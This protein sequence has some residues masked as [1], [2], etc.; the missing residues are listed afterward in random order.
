MISIISVT[1]AV[2]WVF[3]FGFVVFLLYYF[4]S[5]ER[6]PEEAMLHSFVFAIKVRIAA[7]CVEDEG[8]REDGYI[9]T[10]KI[11]AVELTM[12]KIGKKRSEKLR[13]KKETLKAPSIA[14]GSA[15]RML[16]VSVKAYIV[17]CSMQQ[18]EQRWL[19]CS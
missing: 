8:Y 9:E 12:L 1:V 18:Q 19:H 16:Q 14:V 6:M 17:L 2:I 15:V 7:M 4:N 3:F 10:N 13:A 11:V 5:L